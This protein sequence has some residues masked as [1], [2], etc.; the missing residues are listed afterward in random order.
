MGA[1][2]FDKDGVANVVEFA[3]G[4]NP[5]I[6]ASMQLPQPERIGNDFVLTFTQP[7]G[8]SG[9]TY[10]AEWSTTLLPGS[11]TP[12]TD[13]GT[14]GTHTFSVPIGTNDRMFMRIVVTEP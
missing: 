7:G 14:G 3:F 10:G 2:D 8:V 5:T 4:L 13:T 9:I 11:W 1:F 12:I 6:S